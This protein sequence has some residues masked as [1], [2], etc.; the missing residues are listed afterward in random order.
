[1]ACLRPPQRLRT[2]HN[3]PPGAFMEH[4]TDLVMTI[5][6]KA[7][8]SI[9]VEEAEKLRQQLGMDAGAELT[10]ATLIAGFG[11]TITRN[12]AQADPSLALAMG[13]S[14][15]NNETT[16]ADGVMTP[17]LLEVCAQCGK[18][19]SKRCGRCKLTY[20][21]LRLEPATGR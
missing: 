6:S 12:I 9:P 20:A 3:R 17:S 4:A 14:P 1:M 16:S 18:P 11:Q 10:S 5:A 21:G 2:V 15:G 7:A 8:E 19:A 13:L